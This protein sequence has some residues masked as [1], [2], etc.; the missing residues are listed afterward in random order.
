MT[1]ADMR[2]H[3]LLL[4]SSMDLVRQAVY[5]M[6]RLTFSVFHSFIQF[7]KPKNKVDGVYDTKIPLSMAQF[8]A[9]VIKALT[10]KYDIWSK[11]L[12]VSMK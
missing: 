10:L 9:T 6:Y 11:Y 7:F 4:K 5:A 1:L 3:L 8:W 2:L 12:I